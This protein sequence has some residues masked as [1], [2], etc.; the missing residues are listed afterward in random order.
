MT[1]QLDWE[2]TGT[3]EAMAGWLREK[4]DAICVVVI[5]P[6]DSVMAVDASCAAADAEQL[7]K[8]YVP[9]LASR[10]D[11]A[12]REKKSAARVNLEP[13]EE[14]MMKRVLRWAEKSFDFIVG[15]AIL[16][17]GAIDFWVMHRRDSG[18]ALMAL[19]LVLMKLDGWRR[20]N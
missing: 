9:L 5:R 12:R 17:Y 4:S 6:H 20:V 7:V 2:K 1:K 15:P 10:V 18:L 13:M 19:S 3:V 14:R 11:A 16:A 8:D